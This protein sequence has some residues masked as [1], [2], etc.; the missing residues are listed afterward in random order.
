MKFKKVILSVLVLLLVVTLVACG[1]KTNN[2]PV[3]NGAVNK[4]I[5]K[6]AQFLPMQGITASDKEDGDLTDAIVPELGR[7]NKNVVGVYPIT[8]SVTDSDGNTTTVTIE[9][10][11]EANDKEGPMLTGVQDKEI[12]IGDESFSLSD[13]VAASDTVDG[14][15]TSSIVITGTVNP[16]KTGEYQVEYSV[17]DRSDNETKATRKITVGLGNFL[18]EDAVDKEFAKEGDKYQFSLD[19]PKFETAI[20]S[21][22]LVKLEFKVNAA[23]ACE[24]VP[25][26][27]NATSQAKIALQAG[28]NDVTVYFRV[29]AE[30]AGAVLALTAP[31]GASLTFSNVKVSTGEA[32]DKEAPAITFPEVKLV[33]P[34]SVSDVAAL[35]RFAL[36]GVSAK[37]NL[38]GYVSSSLQVSFAGVDLGNFVGEKEIVYTA[39][40]KAGNVAE[41]KRMVTFAK[42]YD[43]HFIADPSF[44]TDYDHTVW[45]LHDTNCNPE[46]YVQDGVLIHH[47]DP[48]YQPSYPSESCPALGSSTETFEA[49]NW[50]LLKFKAKVA[51]ARDLLIRIG[52]ATTAEAGWIENFVGS[53]DEVLHVT[54]D[55]AWYYV[56]FYVHSDVSQTGSNAIAMELKTGGNVHNYD[57][58]REVGNT[59][60][61]DD[62]QFYLVT[63]ENSAP[64]FSVNSNL[65]TTFGKGQEKPDF[66]QYVTAY[67]REDS[68]AIAITA[69]NITESVNMNQAGV[70]DVVYKAV[71]SE[72]KE[73]TFTLKIKVLEEADTVAPVFEEAPNL[74]KEFD[75]NSA[76][77]DITKFV[78]VSDN[79]DGKIEVTMDMIETDADISKAGTYDIVYTAKDSSGNVATYTLKITVKD[80][81][82]PKF[83]GKNKIKTTQGGTITA[84]DII[85]TL[86]VTD[87]VDGEIT[88]TED[89]VKGL[90]NVDFTKFGEYAITV[91][92][93]DA[94][95]NT[96]SFAMK[97]VVKYEDTIIEASVHN[98]LNDTFTGVNSTVATD[99][100]V[101]TIDPSNVGG[102]AS[103]AE[104]KVYGF[105]VEKG[106]MY[107]L[108]LTAKADEAR[109]IQ[110]KLGNGL[111]A[112]PWFDLYTL[113]EDSSQ[114][115]LLGT[116]YAN[117]V[118][119]FRVD[120]T[121]SNPVME[122][123]YG[124]VGHE[125][126]KNHNKIYLTQ[127]ELYSVEYE[128]I[129]LADQSVYILGKG[130]YNSTD[131]SRYNSFIN[132]DSNNTKFAGTIMFTK[133][134]LP[135]GSVIEIADGYQYRPEAWKTNEKQASRPD[136]V[137]T[138]Q[139]IVTDEWWGSYIKRAFNISKV[140]T[141]PF[142]DEADYKAALAAFKIYVPKGTVI[143]PTET[144]DPIVLKDV[145]L[146]DDPTITKNGHDYS[147]PLVVSKDQGAG[148]W[149][150]ISL[151]LDVDF[152]G[153]TKLVAIINGP[154][155]ESFLFKVNDQNDGQKFVTT[156]GADQDVEFD[157]PA[158]F[159]W[160]SSKKTI[161]LFPN[162][163]GAGKAQEF[164]ITKLE[165]QG[166]G[167]ETVNLLTGEL[168]K[169]SEAHY[170][171]LLVISKSVDNTWDSFQLDVSDDIT[172]YKAV[173]YTVKG[174]DG[175]SVLVKPNDNGDCEMTIKLN[176]E[177]QSGI[178]D[179]SSVTLKAGKKAMILFADPGIAGTG[180]PVIF[181]EL[182]FL[183]ELP[184]P[185]P[186]PNPTPKEGVE[187]KSIIPNGT[188]DSGSGYATWNDAHNIVTLGNIKNTV[189]GGAQWARW[190]YAP[191][192]DAGYVKVTV[193]LHVT[194]G[195]KVM[196]KIDTKNTP[197]NNAY[198]TI[199]GNKQTLIAD[200]S[201]VL[202]YVWDLAYLKYQVEK[203][204]KTF[205]VENFEKFVFFACDG[206]GNTELMTTAT[207]E[208]ISITFE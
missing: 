40:D 155:G 42:E 62:F 159:V 94:A 61:F 162:A 123:M 114:I 76:A 1:K 60:Y 90:A 79:I 193:V 167:K 75:Q 8:Y 106:K 77:P 194:P 118:I 37:D 113:D 150:W 36:A 87:N 52:L 86:K 21:F 51:V 203:A 157:L 44:D 26:L 27:D 72:G 174:V 2:K 192:Q 69:A 108:R 187:A 35:T 16:W 59:F 141:A 63:N 191:I 189:E 104:I 163:G 156:T 102:W 65:P 29:S 161:F 124:A 20:S 204:G 89:C 55:W 184:E 22:A 84:A 99:N 207:V 171:K 71:D 91:E 126:D 136:N 176:G 188:A 23:A 185:E 144:P 173:K 46:L 206:T 105:P 68:A 41:V 30:K 28:D 9:I 39:S 83:E 110:I 128:H 139:V 12:V 92:A 4:T 208:L 201:G 183:V 149:R 34:S 131:N 169:D 116:E 121:V 165:L 148:E 67:D 137:T 19:I 158:N 127:F 103:Y 125:G 101:M 178:I 13:G 202:T 112:E 11:V 199:K 120:I 200:E 138:S 197:G 57:R 88:L 48:N 147:R 122:F 78:G 172:Q 33:L 53:D 132:N 58:T 97:V 93:T 140:G 177:I 142:T 135:V 166:E 47:N 45:R 154:E 31:S 168:D 175:K 181:Y 170:R 7:F 107:E 186:N 66:T 14:I 153:Y 25:S 133:E 24:L 143:E 74:V 32:V 15:V 196:A 160:D 119:R 182:T 190:D 134:T 82:A 151:A 111:S 17:K 85:A 56:L 117:Y 164:V 146:L 38:D 179:L 64:Q 18:F 95:G 109:Q 43:T 100:G 54:T 198:D 115:L 80:K 81:E 50:Y 130:Y 49:H 180:D 6:G 129:E 98:Y 96:G 195:L 73:G 70:Y 145:D 205:A 10:T 3:I 152:S 5:E